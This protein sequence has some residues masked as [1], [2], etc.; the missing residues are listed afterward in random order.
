MRAA[1]GLPLTPVLA[2]LRAGLFSSLRYSESLEVNTMN[3][4]H[5]MGGGD[6]Q[7]E[8]PDLDPEQRNDRVDDPDAAPNLTDDD[9]EKHPTVPRVDPDSGA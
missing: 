2:R 9:L 3:D 8:W 7:T 6:A 4:K 5:R 1:N